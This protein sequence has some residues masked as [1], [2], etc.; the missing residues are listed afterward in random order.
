MLGPKQ[1]SYRFSNAQQ[2][3]PDLDVQGFLISPSLRAVVV[4]I[5]VC[6]SAL[7]FARLSALQLVDFITSITS[8]AIVVTTS[9]TLVVPSVIVCHV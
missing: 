5:V 1:H 8:L 9:W 4:V 7:T 6:F 2:L 3:F